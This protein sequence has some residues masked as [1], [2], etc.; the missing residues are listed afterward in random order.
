MHVIDLNEPVDCR[1]ARAARAAKGC[2]R[3]VNQATAMTASF[4]GEVVDSA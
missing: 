4:S 2:C 3:P 1:L